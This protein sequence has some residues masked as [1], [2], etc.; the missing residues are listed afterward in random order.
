MQK[1]GPLKYLFVAAYWVIIMGMIFGSRYNLI[2]P[3]GPA[4]YDDGLVILL[5]K[6]IK[7][8]L[9][10]IIYSIKDVVY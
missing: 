9:V 10:R 8:I 3:I 2:P 5:L 4:E 1:G 6:C 7:R